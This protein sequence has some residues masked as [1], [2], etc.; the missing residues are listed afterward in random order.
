M[1]E[2]GA[3]Y[4]SP[5]TD[6]IEVTGRIADRYAALGGPGGSGL[7]FPTAP[8]RTLTGGGRM[9]RFTDG[10]IVGPSARR[11]HA[12][13]DPIRRRYMGAM[14]GPAGPWGHP[15]TD[16]GTITGRTGLWNRFQRAV[17][18]WS[19][20]TGVHWFERGPLYRRYRA[21]GGAAGH[22]GFPV[23]DQVVTGD[24]HVQVRFEH[25]TITHDP[26]TGEVTVV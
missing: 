13:R 17:A 14:D 20:D 26:D 22:L 11:V 24:G 15:I 12:V 7:G 19:P 1:F 16:T 9:Q 6:A 4:M 5:K 21:E 10:V 8:A 23:S 3:I 18:Y 2:R 25:G